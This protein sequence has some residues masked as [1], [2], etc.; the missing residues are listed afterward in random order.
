MDCL[1]RA[2][3]S[4]GTTI[5]A[6]IRIDLINITLR[7]SFNGTL[8]YAGSASSAIVIDLVSHFFYF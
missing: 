1:N 2:N 7:Y 5:G 6:D 8:I 4:A 3:I